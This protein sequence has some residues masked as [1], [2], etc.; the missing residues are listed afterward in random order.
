MSLDTARRSA[1]ATEVLDSCIRAETVTDDL[2]DRALAVDE[3]R[4]FLSIVVERLGDLFEP[5]LCDV[6]EEL[7]PRVIR[8]V[9]PELM[10][11]VRRLQGS[12][13][14]PN[15]VERIYVLSRVTLGADVAVT[16]VLID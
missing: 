12:P 13:A 16:S 15:S 8:R 7:F 3:G 1:C 6:Y 4:A 11:R 5:R 9:F 10:P 2:L 14:P